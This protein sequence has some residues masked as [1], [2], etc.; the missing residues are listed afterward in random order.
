MRV[1]GQ[2]PEQEVDPAQDLA[3]DV[4]AA[5]VD[6]HEVDPEDTHAGPVGDTPEGGRPPQGPQRLH[7][8]AQVAQ[9]GA[10]ALQVRGHLTHMV[11]RDVEGDGC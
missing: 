9:V 3:E 6:H 2:R 4:Q 10:V 5:A 7:P 8:P 1:K 11:G